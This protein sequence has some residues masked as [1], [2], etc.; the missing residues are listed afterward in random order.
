MKA[1]VIEALGQA[2]VYADFPEPEARDDALVATVEAAALTNLTRGLASGKHY[3]SSGL[4]LPGVAGVDGVARLADGRRVYGTAVSPYGMM[5][6]RTLMP[7]GRTVELPDGI[8]SVLAAA[9]P[10]PG[11]SAWVSLRHAAGVRPEHHVLV[12][13]ATGVT[14][15]LAVQLA[16]TEFGVQRVVAVGRD[17][18]RLDWLRS[19]GADEVIR[20]GHDDLAAR[21]AAAHRDRP[22]DAVIDYLWGEPAEQVLAALGNQGLGAVAHATQFVQVGTMAGPTINLAGGILRSAAVTLRGVGLGSVPMELLRQANQEFLPRLFGMLAGG[23]VQLT[24]QRQPLAD[25]E[26]VWTQREPSGTRVVFT[27]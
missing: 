19:V 22:F 24:T 10:N 20:L 23:Q 7:P 17:A 18:G 8:D 16:K 14:G 1:A 11:V 21:V 27:P 25:V 13:G 5:A 6:E 4:V 15:S 12:L 2:P 3:G 9:A 26:R